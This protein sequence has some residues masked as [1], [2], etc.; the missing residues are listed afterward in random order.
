M[1]EG[2]IFLLPPLSVS[3]NF[4]SG[5]SI[6]FTST[7]AGVNWSRTESKIIASSFMIKSG[8]SFSEEEFAQILISSLTALIP[9]FSALFIIAILMSLGDII[10]HHCWCLEPNWWTEDCHCTE[11]TAVYTHGESRPPAFQPSTS[12]RYTESCRAS[13]KE[14]LIIKLHKMHLFCHFIFIHLICF[15]SK[16]LNCGSYQI[17]IQEKDLLYDIISFIY[18]NLTS[19]KIQ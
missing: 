12:L 7:R 1:K 8:W 13:H 4:S 6:L 11:C 2:L 14:I 17:L 16:K 9:S 15:I 19:V 5:M 3:S 18:I 10:N